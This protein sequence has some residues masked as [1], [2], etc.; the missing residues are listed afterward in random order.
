MNPSL[1]LIIGPMFSGKTS[2]LIR[3]LDTYSKANFKV[4]YINS[5]T[6][7]RSTKEFST[8]N[9]TLSE[10]QSIDMIK[11]CSTLTSLH[12]HVYDS[13][14]VIGIDEAQ[15]FTDLVDFYK[16]I[17][18]DKKKRLIVC[19]LNGTSERKLFG[20]IAELIPVCD[21][22]TFLH[23]FCTYCA[24]N[25]QMVKAPF[26]KRIVDLQPT[27]CIGGIESYRPVCRHHFG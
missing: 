22:V 12:E 24:E 20:Q 5:F 11:A 26:S 7:S 10:N 8:H 15:F 19:G 16:L 25:K 23:S 4:L 2:E 21:D 9:S 6:D 14:D 27:V 18:E 3:K 17:V 1:E 13:Y